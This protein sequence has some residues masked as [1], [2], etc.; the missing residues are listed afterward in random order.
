M[1]TSHA[2]EH[3]LRTAFLIA[4]STL[5]FVCGA[6]KLPVASLLGINAMHFNLGM[7]HIL[8]RVQKR[9]DRT[10][11]FLGDYIYYRK[12]NHSRIMAWS[13]AK[14]HAVSNISGSQ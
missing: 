10:R 6:R 14:K 3:Y 13:M 2:G 9:V 5:R 7:P 8:Y 12:R 4:S 11:K 1:H